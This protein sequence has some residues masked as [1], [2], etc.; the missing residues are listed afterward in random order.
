MKITCFANFADPQTYPFFTTLYEKTGHQFLLA[1][2][3]PFEQ[4][5][6][7]YGYEDLNE[8]VFVEK[9]Y[10]AEDPLKKAEE[11]AITCLITRKRSISMAEM[12]ILPSS[13]SGM[14]SWQENAFMNWQRI[15]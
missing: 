6:L 1:A 5:L 15:S 11:L 12:H 13:M 3:E 2:T 4:Q 9:L 7:E 14:V 8:S 10:M